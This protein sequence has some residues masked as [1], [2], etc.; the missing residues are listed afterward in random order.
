MTDDGGPHLELANGIGV[1]IGHLL[2]TLV[3]E[4]LRVVMRLCDSLRVIGPAWCEG[5]IA[6]LFKERAPVVLTGRQ[7]IEA[8][9]EDDGLLP[10]RIG[11]VDLLLFLGRQICHSKLLCVGL[12]NQLD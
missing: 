6:L 3:G 9:D 4:G 10:C 7:E 5:R 1:V 11:T 2:D 8:V 12:V